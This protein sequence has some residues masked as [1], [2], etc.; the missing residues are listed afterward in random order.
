MSTVDLVQQ[1]VMRDLVRGALSPG[2][3]VRQDELAERLGVSKIPVREAL[4][5]LTALGLLRIEPNRGVVVPTLSADE[6]EEN[7]SLR[8]AI[9]PVLLK[10]AMRAISIVDL[11]E[12]EL[13]LA[14]GSVPTMSSTE[15]NWAFHRALYR[16]SGWDR[17]LAMAEILHASVAPYVE[18]YTDGLGGNDASQAEHRALLDAARE[19]NVRAANGLLLRHLDNAAAALLDYLD[20]DE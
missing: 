3:W 20:T 12:A 13:A 1:A 16:A 17:G 18:L 14:T 7:Y 19:G 5:R 10:R 4:Q 15:Q 9:E 11:A 8:R 2:S 6:A